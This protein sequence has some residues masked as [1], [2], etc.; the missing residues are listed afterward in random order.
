VTRLWTGQSGIEI[1]K[2]KEIFLLLKTSR[3]TLQPTHCSTQWVWSGYFANGKQPG[4]EAVHS[5]LSST[6]VQNELNVLYTVQE[7]LCIF[8]KQS[9]LVHNFVNIHYYQYLSVW[10]FFYIYLQHFC[11]LCLRSL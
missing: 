1:Q 9:L 11:N 2:G 3:P 8:M 6:K 10:I 4:D 5:P 7:Q